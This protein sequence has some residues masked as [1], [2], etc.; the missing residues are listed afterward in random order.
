MRRVLAWLLLRPGEKLIRVKSWR[1][2]RGEYG[3]EGPTLLIDTRQGQRQTV[4]PVWDKHRL[5]AFLSAGW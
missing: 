2:V 4:A 5:R 1:L 3:I